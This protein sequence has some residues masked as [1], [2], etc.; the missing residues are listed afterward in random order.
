MR[1]RLLWIMLITLLV[2]A[3]GG[4]VWSAP[5]PQQDPLFDAFTFDIRADLELLGNAVLGE[6]VRPDNWTFNADVT[7][8]TM[9]ADL[10]YDNEQL[11]NTIFGVGIVNR[12][13]NWFS[14]AGS[15]APIIAR[16]VRHDLE[17]AADVA[18]GINVRPPEWRGGPPLM[19]CDRTIQNLVDILQRVFAVQPSTPESVLNYCLSVAAEIEDDLVEAVFSSD[20]LSGLPQLI[21][22]IRGDLERLADETLG[23]NNRPADWIGNRDVNS[24][25]LAGDIYL[26][27][28]NLADVLLGEGARPDGWIGAISNTPATTY[29]NLRHDLELLADTALAPG[30]RPTGWQG[31]EPLLRC[32]PLDQYLVLLVQAN[33]SVTLTAN[34]AAP[35]FCVLLA[36]A[37]NQAAENPPVFDVVETEQDERFGAESNFAFAYLDLAATQYMG[38]MPGGTPIRAWYRGFAD[39]DMMFVS[40]DDF[41]VFVDYQFTTLSTLQFDSLPTLEGENPLTFCDAVWCNGPG[42]TPTPTGFGALSQLLAQAT[43]PAPGTPGAGV[44]VTPGVGIVDKVQV[45]WNN[46]RVTY[47]LDNPEGRTAQVA[48]EICRQPALNATACEPVVSVVD[49]ATNT[50]RQ[51]ISQYNGL[52]VY[53]FRYG[54]ST[55]LLIE[56]ATTFSNDI[57]I[58]DPTIR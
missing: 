57:W 3:T 46:I 54:Y 30:E 12:P 55:G 48:L 26:D 8:P 40:G 5:A 14:A 41:A 28:E 51:P 29:L 17:L 2:M 42:P 22:A 34:A 7:S 15:T 1:R 10:W 27:L 25:T 45:S 56:G 33:Y 6:G 39:S 50:Q 21:L 24:P 47:L 35:D 43:P 31:S 23:L 18:L 53:D 4:S 52:N 19:R 9:V 44:I 37:A 32:A 49:T 58:S 36:L 11:A 20:Q 16:N 13:L 38:I